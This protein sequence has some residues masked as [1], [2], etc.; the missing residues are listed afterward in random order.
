MAVHSRNDTSTDTMKFLQKI[1]SVTKVIVGGEE[2]AVH[3]SRQETVLK[4]L[5]AHNLIAR[6]HYTRLS[7]SRI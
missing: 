1:T 6:N 5:T 3:Y 2:K 4:D 7:I